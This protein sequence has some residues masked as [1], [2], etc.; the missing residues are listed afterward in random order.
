MG[1]KKTKKMKLI[2]VEPTE[3]R[4]GEPRPIKESL[5]E[6]IQPIR[7]LAAAV[8][9]DDEYTPEA[10]RQFRTTATK[11]ER[12]AWLE[13]II[14]NHGRMHEVEHLRLSR[15]QERWSESYAKVQAE[16]KMLSDRLHT[17]EDDLAQGI[18]AAQAYIPEPDETDSPSSI[19]T[20][21][22]NEE[23][24]IGDRFVRQ[25]VIYVVSGFTPNME[26]TLKSEY[27]GREWNVTD[28]ELL[29]K[30]QLIQPEEISKEAGDGA[31]ATED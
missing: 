6:L 24:S 3:R 8:R 30:F 23:V 2:D 5:A 18:E 9:G 7:N 28:G 19:T 14:D 10:L 26:I 21:E 15:Y 4:L 17:I 16:L 29:R 27:T 20:S 12:L 13:R 11:K 22:T 1:K 25:G 31:E